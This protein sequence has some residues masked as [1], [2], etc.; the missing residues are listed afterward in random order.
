MLADPKR[1]LTTIG[2]FRRIASSPERLA[3]AGE[4]G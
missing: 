4:R 3:N 1:Q 2:L